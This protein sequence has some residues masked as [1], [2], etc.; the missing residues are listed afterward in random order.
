MSN[1][2]KHVPEDTDIVMVHDAAR[3]F[4]YGAHHQDCAASAIRCG[5]GVA[6]IGATDTIKRAKDGVIIETIL[7]GSWLLSRRRRR[8]RGVIVR[9]YRNGR[10]TGFLAR[11]TP[12]SWSASPKACISLRL[13]GQHQAMTRTDLEKGRT[14]LPA[15]KT[16]ISVSERF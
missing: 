12:R 13:S 10:K 7:A 6:G 5:S 8:L 15:S 4:C 14:S 3:C 11:M 16:R 2:L 1:A 9:A